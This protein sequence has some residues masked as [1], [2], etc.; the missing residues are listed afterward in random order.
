MDPPAWAAYEA[1]KLVFEA[2]MAVGT[3]SAAA[4]LAYL[5]DPQLQ[6]SI[7]KDRLASLN[8]VDN[9]L[10]QPLYTVR[11]TPYRAEESLLNKKL[12]RVELVRVIEREELSTE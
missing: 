8:H 6:F 12:G 4:L 7:D 1:V 5:T 10:L 2:A 11:I 3:D 9:E